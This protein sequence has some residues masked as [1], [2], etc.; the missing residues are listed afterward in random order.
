MDNI[1]LIKQ[2]SNQ[3]EVCRLKESENRYLDKTYDEI[4]N[5]IISENQ[6]KSEHAYN[7][8]ISNINKNDSIKSEVK[9]AK[10]ITKKHQDKIGAKKKNTKEKRTNR[11]V[12]KDI[13]AENEALNLSTTSSSVSINYK[14]EEHVI[15]STN[16]TSNL[17]TK[18]PDIEELFKNNKKR[19][20]KMRKQFQKEN[21]NKRG[22]N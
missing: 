8:L 15:K 2:R 18:T 13:S 11:K 7:N 3:Y 12:D 10:S 9:L 14:L 5:L 17:D 1:Y 6:L 4:E 19:K 22:I 21:I 20:D 16:T